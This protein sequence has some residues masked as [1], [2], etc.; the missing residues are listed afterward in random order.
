M[1]RPRGG[2]WLEREVSNW[3]RERLDTLVSLLTP[4]E[5]K[6]FELDGEAEQGRSVGIKVLAFPIEDRGVPVDREAFAELAQ[7]LAAKF[8]AGRNVGVH[9]RQGIGRSGL[10]ATA[11]LLDAGLELEPALKAVAAARGVGI[12]ETAEQ[13]RWI[14]EYARRTFALARPA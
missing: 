14:E 7:D 10:L 8:A 1:P 9:C 2:D 3:Q 12:P 11:V 5:E 4:A 13:R 6:E